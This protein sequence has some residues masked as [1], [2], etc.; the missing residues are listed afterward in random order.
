MNAQS[1]DR[2]CAPPVPCR[3]TRQG[4]APASS[5][6]MSESG[7]LLSKR[8]GLYAEPRLA[9]DEE[10]VELEILPDMEE[11]EDLGWFASEAGGDLTPGQPQTSQRPR[12][13]A[14][15]RIPCSLLA[16]GIFFAL[17]IF[18]GLWHPAWLILL[19]PPF[20]E[21]I[22]RL[23]HAKDPAAA[24][25]T[26][27][28]PLFAVFLFLCA[29]ILLDRWHPVLLLTIPLYRHALRRLL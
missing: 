22:R 11:G 17:G 28:Y 15:R 16:W 9:N 6:A 25:A 4:A 8:L 2:L 5:A 27:P 24:L 12:T 7:R 21:P 23:R 20:Y 26:F 19:T 14:A 10:E 13:P 18:A 1:A 29:G 3:R